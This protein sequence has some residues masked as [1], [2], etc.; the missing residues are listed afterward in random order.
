MP[1]A[2]LELYDIIADTIPGIVF[3]YLISALYSPIFL[4]H[5]P[6]EGAGL[7]LSVIVGGYVTGRVIHALSSFI[8]RYVM[9][10]IGYLSSWGE[11]PKIYDE[12]EV[13]HPVINDRDE[14]TNAISTH[15]KRQ[16]AEQLVYRSSNIYGKYNTLY[17]FYRNFVII[18]LVTSI[19]GVIQ[20]QH[21]GKT[22]YF[23]ASGFLFS[24]SYYH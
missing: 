13:D 11:V 18:F 5:L 21:T 7:A 6:F 14:T 12:E 15:R 2:Q 10:S 22:N 23:L 3:L 19:I 9:K 16:F 4:N 1:V 8:E 20:F 17:M 24:F